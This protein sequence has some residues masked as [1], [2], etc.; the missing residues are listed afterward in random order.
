[1]RWVKRA[2]WGALAVTLVSLFALRLGLGDRAGLIRIASV[3]AAPAL[4][5]EPPQHGAPEWQRIALPFD[6]SPRGDG[7]ARWVRSEF[8]LTTPPEEPLQL[9]IA[10]MGF[11]GEIFVNGAQ[12]ASIGRGRGGWWGRR[13]LVWLPIPRERLRP[14]TNELTLRVE[15]LPEFAGYLTP[16]FLGPAEVLQ[17]YFRA[18]SAL[19]GAPDVVALLSFALAVLYLSIY[20]RD[21]RAE[22][23]LQSAAFA[24][25]F[26]A[27]LAWRLVDY[28]VWPLGVGAAIACVVVAGHRVAQLSRPRVEAGLVAGLALL[29]GCA[30]LLSPT[31]RYPLAL[32]TATYDLVAAAYLLRIYRIPAVAAWSGRGSLLPTGVAVGLALAAC[33]V[34][35]FWDRSP[36]FGVPLFSIAHLPVAVASFLHLVTFLSDGLARERAL[37]ASLQASQTRLVALERERAARA[38]RERMQRD[39]HDGL[40]AQLVATLALAERSPQDGAALA[41]SV[42]L[43]MGELRAAVDSLDSAERGLDEALGEL[44]GR[45]EP[46][47]QGAGL[48]LHWRVGDVDGTPRL[49]PEQVVHLQ[50]VLQEAIANAVKHAGASAL[51]LHADRDAS[52]RTF[53][54]VRDDGRGMADA[55][56]GRGLGNLRARAAQLGAEI[57]V[58]SSPEGTRVRLWFAAA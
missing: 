56:P 23:A 30:L 42:R 53:I 12:V 46:L 29:A 4:G 16:A 9:L 36:L 37:N 39:L 1:M 15:A 50:R 32:A 14:G 41:R 45:L 26:L 55:A 43:A 6:W 19:V 58:D 48:P 38:E 21:R 3:I 54:E 47:A 13:E 33:D 18:R 25:L 31:L 2:L 28:L 17:P 22:W 10:Q 44:R 57:A 35:L 11:G 27:G 8:A 34:P 20:S 52:G 24:M 5:D 40:G 49:K 7:H 51:S